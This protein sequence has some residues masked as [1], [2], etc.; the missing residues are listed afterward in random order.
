MRNGTLVNL[1]IG[2]NIVSKRIKCREKFSN[3]V[4]KINSFHN[5][6]RKKGKDLLNQAQSIPVAIDKGT[7]LHKKQYR[8]RLH[9]SARLTKAL[10]NGSL[11]FH[12]HDES[13]ESLYRG[14]F[15]EFLI[16]FGELSEEIGKVILGNAPGNNQMTSPSIQKELCNC[17][18]E[19]V[20]KRIFEELNDDVFSILVDESRDISKKEQMA[21]VLRYVDKLGFVKERFIG[22]VHV[23]ETTALSLK[24]AIDDLFARH[25]LSIG[26][27]RGQ[28]YDGASNMSGEFNGLKALILKENSS[29]YHVHCF[30]HQLQL[31]VV[32]L[33]TKHY[34]I[35]R[36]YKELSN[37]VNVVGGSCKR[38]DLL[39][40]SQRESLGLNSEVET[41]SGK[42]QE[43]SLARAGDTRWSSHEKTI[44]RLLTLYPCV[45]DV[46][47][48]IEKLGE[49]SNYQN[50]SRGLQ[51]FIKTFNFVFYL[52]L[53]KYILGVTNTLCQALQRKDQDM[54]N[55]VKLVKLTDEG[56]K[57]YRLEGF[58]SLLEDVT[59]FCEKY[60]IEVVDMEAEYVDPRFKRKKTSITN[61]HHY[62][63]NNFNTVLDMQI[64]ELGSRFNEVTT[65]L[66]TNISSLSPSCNFSAFSIVNLIN[67]AEMYPC[68]FDFDE[69]D[70]LV[71][72]L[73]HYITNVKE[74]KRFANLS[75]LGDLAKMMV[76]TRLPID[77]PLV[78]R[79]IK[80]S[81][82]LPVATASVERC[83]S[84]MK[85][86]KTDLRNRMG[87][88]YMNDSCICYIEREFLQ[89]VSVEEVMQRFQK[90]KTR[91]EQ[92]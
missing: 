83:F 14:N 72:E 56:L 87:D 2:W 46:L 21:V 36:L 5:K 17:F 75:G 26:R 9:A 37:L 62:V 64:Q 3:H 70:K 55:A 91:R 69:K 34:E 80:L 25:N 51:E 65:K 67:L 43:L 42:N 27:V 4:G 73:G 54:L 63:V 20:L 22:L 13:E 11:A 92:L 59:S 53:M 68:D 32:G 28:G 48:Y 39:R 1:E 58:D 61:R 57:R 33:A 29:A 12:G 44:L 90:M 88:E 50:E 81:L 38:I 18:A 71:Y 78:Y 60:E 23:M 79:L 85:N 7:D 30:A 41:G 66:L 49:F 16:V 47:E 15:I 6:A 84:S 31:V 86:V 19:E 82:V 89:Q 77:Y 74:D 40:E 76:K 8:I 10:L 24:A 35:Y 52:H 45:I